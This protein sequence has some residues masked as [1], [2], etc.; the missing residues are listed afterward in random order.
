MSSLSPLPPESRSLPARLEEGAWTVP[1]NEEAGGAL[2]PAFLWSVFR[3]RWAWSVSLGALLASGVLAF[4]WLT[5]EPMYD[6]V[7]YLRIRERPPEIVQGV[8]VDDPRRFVAT[9]I[10]ILRSPLVLGPVLSRPEVARIPEIQQAEDPQYWLKERL[11]VRGQGESE[12]F[13]V[14]FQ[15][16]DPRVAKTVVDAVVEVYLSLYSSRT[17]R[18]V[19]QLL[20]ALRHERDR[21]RQEVVQ[22]EGDLRRMARENPESLAPRATG[23]GPT[24]STLQQTILA[25][26]QQLVETQVQQRLLRARLGSAQ[27][28]GDE[29][30][31]GEAQIEQLVD[32]R[33]EIR[34]HR[35]L[36]R[37][38]ERQLEDL[39]EQP[40]YRPGTRR[41][42]QELDHIEELR[43]KLDELRET[44]RDEI[45]GRGDLLVTQGHEQDLASLRNHARELDAR[46]QELRNRLAV[47]RARLEQ[48]AD[49]AIQME[50]KQKELN[51]AKDLEQTIQQR[52][53]LVS[54]ERNP[55][56]N[57]AQVELLQ[58]SELP[59]R[60]VETVPL[61]LMA[62][63]GAGALGLPFA[64]FLAW[65]LLMR[66]VTTGESMRNVPVEM[67][68]EVATMPTR[69]LLLHALAL[70]RYEEQQ[71][72]FDQ[73]LENLHSMLSVERH[74]RDRRIILIT[75]SIRGEGKT[76]IASH[77]AAHWARG[78]AESVLLVDA[79]LR[80]PAI[81]R[82][83]ELDNTVGLADVLQGRCD[84]QQAIV[85]WDGGLHILP[86]GR[87]T[88]G[89]YELFATGRLA[90]L[91]EQWRQRFDRIIIDSPPLLSAAETLH[92]AKVVD[93]VLFT[94]RSEFTRQEQMKR[95][96]HKLLHAGIR[97]FAAVL[98][99][100]PTS[101]YAYRY[102]RYDHPHQAAVAAGEDA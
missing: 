28:P 42:Q 89:V 66:R 23:M 100:V 71:A 63:G 47:E 50:L 59:T 81:H 35:E 79:D 15:A 101:Q 85:N 19:Q 84:W 75:S 13:S 21:Q 68:G 5:F 54:V 69:P 41:Y 18:E 57:T 58:T 37:Q 90:P 38:R 72:L 51:Q 67:V 22:L 31:L 16:S 92:L 76:S 48:S 98:N 53:M 4:V 33:D 11:R 14:I 30:R 6:A 44:A 34:A 78:T 74:A 93:G 60:P 24:T 88:G 43:R 45:A 87:A 55:Q 27:A 86:A 25:L 77:L 7:A 8:Q 17:D 102:D 82:R 95:A 39:R 3:R 52:M 12:I 70:R 1:A 64:L 36:I 32:A 49:D 65:E 80:S 62:V 40:L 10:E 73:S 9:Q 83:F 46:E 96:T 61:K 2:S 97:P 56:R 91:L 99:G 29:S 20:T 26:N 94:A